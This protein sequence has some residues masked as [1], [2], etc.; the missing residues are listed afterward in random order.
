MP[1]TRSRRGGSLLKGVA[2]GCCGA[3]LVATVVAFILYQRVKAKPPPPPEATLSTN[4]TAGRPLSPPE[5]PL[6][7]QIEEIQRATQSA[8]PESVD[9]DIRPDQLTDILR[10]RL[11]AEGAGDIDVYFGDSTVVVQAPVNFQGSTLH[12]TIRARPFVEEGNLRLEIEDAEVGKVTMPSAVRQ[13]LQ[14]T[15]DEAL[16]DNPPQ[17]TGVYLESVEIAPERMLVRGYTVPR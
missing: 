5:R 6:D 2:I 10:E 9:L 4:T 11:E 12:A 1:M 15:I 17:R 7:Q 13:R 3:S 14:D 16:R 8:Q